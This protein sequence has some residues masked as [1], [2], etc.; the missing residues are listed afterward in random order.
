[1]QLVHQLLCVAMK[2]HSGQF[3]GRGK[4]LQ[5]RQDFFLQIH[6][7]DHISAALNTFY[8][9]SAFHVF[10]HFSTYVNTFTTSVKWLFS[11]FCLFALLYGAYYW[12]PVSGWIARWCGC[13]FGRNKLMAAIALGPKVGKLKVKRNRARDKISLS[14][15]FMGPWFCN[16]CCW[17][18]PAPE[19]YLGPRSLLLPGW[20]PQ[21]HTWY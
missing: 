14:S 11:I 17:H 5:D 8:L 20:K 7:F 12:F 3:R 9:I 6:K 21:R 13:Y 15:N 2:L 4:Y 19:E 16:N 18:T 10:Y 1:M